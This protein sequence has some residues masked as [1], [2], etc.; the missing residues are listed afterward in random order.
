MSF[1]TVDGCHNYTVLSEADRAQ[2]HIVINASNYKW[3]DVDLVP[4]WY[5]FQGAAGDRMAD[6][7]VPQDHCGTQNPSWLS[8]AHPTIAEGVVTRGVCV[9]SSYFCCSWKPN[10][11][12]KN[13]GAYFVYELVKQYY[14][15]SRY[16]GNGRVGKLTFSG[17][18]CFFVSAGSQNRD[19]Y[20]RVVKFV[21]IAAERA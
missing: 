11:R 21:F 4:G 13:C 1:L 9:S 16:C 18:F 5:R 3:D 7:C 8:G 12:I 6:K 17:M 20:S 19:S 2:G 15:N 10:I 14:W